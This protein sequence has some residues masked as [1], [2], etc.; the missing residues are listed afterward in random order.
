MPDRDLQRKIGELLRELR[1]WEP[2]EA[3]AT[4]LELAARF[5][6]D[7]FIVRRLASAEGYDLGEED[8]NATADP[9]ASTIDLDPETVARARLA[10]SEDDEEDPIDP[11][12]TTIDLD[13]EAVRRALE[14]TA[15]EPD[16]DTGVWKR[17]RQTGEWELVKADED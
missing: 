6:L 15:A 14:D 8:P 16:V 12:A 17:N 9:N 1:S 4:V 13:P 3:R 11:N 2:D 7:P 5:S 10:S